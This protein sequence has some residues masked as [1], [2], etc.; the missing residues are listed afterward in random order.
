M[1]AHIRALQ[2]GLGLTADGIRGKITTAAI[3]SAADQGRLT[4]APRPD[5]GLGDFRGAAKRL[6]D[7]DL[8]LIGQMIGVGE[9]ELH[10][11]MDVEAPGSGF[12]DH[13]RPKMLFEPHIFWREVGP[14]SARDEAARRGLAY[15]GWGEKPYPRDSYARLVAAM[16]IAP[17]AALRSASWGRGQIMGFNAGLAGYADAGAMVRAFMADEEEHIRAM[18]RFIISTGLDDELRRHDWAGFARGYNGSAYARHGYH[19]RL[20]GA[21]AKWAKIKDT[22]LPV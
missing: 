15:A 21:F 1:N 9:D 19:T 6:D 13:G 12:D 14:G 8:P 5:H 3:L 16:A 10:A 4:V 7:V 17:E 22:P 2:E 11:V 18:V 20:A